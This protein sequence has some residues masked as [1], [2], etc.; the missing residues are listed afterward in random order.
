MTFWPAGLAVLYPR[1][2]AL[3]L[4]AMVFCGLVL[5]AISAAVLFWDRR[6]RRYALVGW[7]WYAGMLVPVSG[8]VAIG[9]QSMADRY[10]Y[11]PLIGVFMALVWG[12][13]DLILNSRLRFGLV[14]AVAGVLLALCAAGQHSP[15]GLLARQRDLVPAW[16]IGH[17]E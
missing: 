16:I 13:A 7:L 8:L 9:D 5:L 14:W 2:R 1:D 6:G 12:A 11:L 17:G 10:T 15:G 3:N 4:P